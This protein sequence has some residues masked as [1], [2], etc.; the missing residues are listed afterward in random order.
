MQTCLETS[1]SIPRA[2]M[3]ASA[4]AIYVWQGWTHSVAALNK[5]P[6]PLAQ[7]LAG[8]PKAALRT[9]FDRSA[10]QRIWDSAHA[11]SG[12][13]TTPQPCTIP[14]PQAAS[15][16]TAVPDHE[17]LTAMI[18]YLARQAAQS[19][20]Q[21]NRRAHAVKLQFAGASG[22][23]RTHRALL[24]C[25]TENAEEICVAAQRLLIHHQ[26]STDPLVSVNLTVETFAP[27]LP[28]QPIN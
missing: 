3:A 15:E 17:I 6:K 7:S 4:S 1:L 10:A 24:A 22:S 9:I 16:R 14:A 2:T 12:A 21:C 20:H 5:H 23:Q 8:V 27:D 26:T 28:Q 19:L 25:P 18:A 11:Q 13:K